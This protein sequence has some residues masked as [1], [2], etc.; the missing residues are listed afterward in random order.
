MSYKQLNLNQDAI[1][2]AIQQFA[3]ENGCTLSEP[4]QKKDFIEFQ[5]NRDGE[6]TALLQIYKKN[7]GTTT[8]HP[9]VGKNQA[10]SK[11]VADYVASST[12]RDNLERRP[13]TLGNLTQDTWD[14]LR[15]YLQED[16]CKIEDQPLQH[17][18]RISV[19]GPQK[20]RVFLH[21]YNTGRFLMQGRPL[22]LYAMISNFLAEF[23]EDKREILAAQLQVEQIPTTVDQLYDEL[24]EHLPMSAFYL[25]DTGCAVIAPA[26]ALIKISQDLPDYTYVA[27]PALKGLEFYMKQLLA[28]NDRPVSPKMGLAAYFTSQGALKSDY[29]KTIG[30]GATINAI[31][32]SYCIHSDHRNG[33][34]H[35][36]GFAP[37][38]TRIIEDKSVAAD[39]VY[40]VL[41]TIEETYSVILVNRAR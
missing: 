24:R 31:E 2:P 30:C 10:L 4:V 28:D 39:I 29:I 34:F 14:L 36:D 8:L 25:G 18:V 32:K 15:A 16:N 27:F 41:R 17:G 22:A 35:A 7:D 6:A 13:L 37:E 26:I 1:T 19:T 33:L 38:M 21:R 40:S 5:I 9:A 20:D 11:L 12:K 23:H 3:Q